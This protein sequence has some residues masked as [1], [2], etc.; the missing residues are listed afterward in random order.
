MIP[1]TN[2]LPSEGIVGKREPRRP[3]IG[4][5]P[6]KKNIIPDSYSRLVKQKNI[7]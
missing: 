1:K 3:L 6:Y 4:I 7:N 5:R 2:A